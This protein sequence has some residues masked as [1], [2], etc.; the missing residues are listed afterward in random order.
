MLKDIFSYLLVLAVFLVLDIVWIGFVAKKFYN[1]MLG[2]L[3]KKKPNWVAAIIFYLLYVSGIL[4]FVVGPALSSDSISYAI[5]AGAFF[6]L[7][8]YATY[9]LTNLATVKGWPLKLTV[10]DLVWGSVL[11]SVTSVL[12]FILIKTLL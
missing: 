1:K 8:S 9:D 12:S 6:G 11:T 3:M 2:Y 10:I 5:F 7:L 4:F